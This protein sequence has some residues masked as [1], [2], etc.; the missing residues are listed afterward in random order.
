M[1]DLRHEV[2]RE[3]SGKPKGRRQLA[4]E[5]LQGYEDLNRAEQ[6]LG[7]MLSEFR[8]LVGLERNVDNATIRLIA[9]ALV[10]DKA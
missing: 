10:E 2:E 4:R 6:K 3:L 9:R 7:E 8:L 5:L 1:T